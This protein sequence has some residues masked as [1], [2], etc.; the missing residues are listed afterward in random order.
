MFGDLSVDIEQLRLGGGWRNPHRNSMLRGAESELEWCLVALPMQPRV[1]LC[2]EVVMIDKNTGD[3]D[4]ERDETWKEKR[5]KRRMTKTQG[6]GEKD[7][8]NERTEKEK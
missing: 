3:A 6:D 2:Q 8:E 7:T 1:D 5:R 4:G